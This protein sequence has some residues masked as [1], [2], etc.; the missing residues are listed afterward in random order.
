MQQVLPF[1]CPSNHRVD[2]TN[3][4]R[5]S[6][7]SFECRTCWWD[8]NKESI[9]AQRAEYQRRLEEVAAKRPVPVREPDRSV[10]IRRKRSR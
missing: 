8:A 6:D 5:L 1:F 3:A 2:G 9:L 10:N 7:G 4:K